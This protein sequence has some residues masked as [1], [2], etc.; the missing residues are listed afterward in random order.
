MRNRRRG[1]EVERKHEAQILT[2]ACTRAR[3]ISHL[4]KHA[5]AYLGRRNARS[6]SARAQIASD[7]SSRSCRTALCFPIALFSHLPFGLNPT[8]LYHISS[9]AAFLT[10]GASRGSQ[11]K[12]KPIICLITWSFGRI[13][14]KME[15]CALVKRISL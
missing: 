14:S 12:Y 4:P 3:R 15:T 5:P 8:G 11:G 2:P 6:E 13:V 1:I 7:R 9:H 10:Q